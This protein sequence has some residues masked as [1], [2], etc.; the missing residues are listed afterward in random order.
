MNSKKVQ[1]GRSPQHTEEI[2]EG[3]KAFCAV[4]GTEWVSD[5]E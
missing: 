5:T 2:V 3:F 1:E 4:A